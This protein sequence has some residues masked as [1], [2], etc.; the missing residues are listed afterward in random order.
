[1][2]KVL[3]HI[4]PHNDPVNALASGLAKAFPDLDVVR[5]ESEQ[6]AMKQIQ[7]A[8]VLMAFSPS[9]TAK[10]VDAGERLTWIQ[11]LNSGADDMMSVSSR[12]QEVLV[13]SGRGAQATPVSEAVLAFLLA[14]VRDLPRLCRNQVEH[15]WERFPARLLRGQTVVILG[16]G[17][18]AECLAPK[19]AALG[20]R[21]LGL[22]HSP[23]SLPGFEEVR[24]L[25]QL[26]PTIAVADFLVVLTPLTAATRG[27]V[28]REV[29]EALQPTASLINV[30]RGAVVDEPALIELL[31]KGRIAGAALDVFNEEPLPA[32]HP[33]WDCPNVLISPHLAG[34]N[35]N[36]INDVLQIVE[37]NL[38]A[39]VAGDISAM[40][41][42]I[43]G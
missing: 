20:M 33:L 37:A 12:M 29:L 5:T 32:G 35:T 21:V 38:R 36:Y 15:R 9:V 34:W 25:Q 27:L 10:L 16:V 19:C 7:D 24:D 6:Q 40:R 14:L 23:R 39:W 26:L 2:S 22:S 4:A 8:E 18:I 42:R 1:M 17:A 3:I 43:S 11:T 13:T 41:N 30:A 28:S 31:K